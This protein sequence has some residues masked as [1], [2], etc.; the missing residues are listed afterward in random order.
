V[1]SRERR[2]REPGMTKTEVREA[3]R[4][5]GLSTADKPAAA[6]LASRFAYGVRITEEGLARVE[7]AEESLLS[8]GF[9]VVRVRD[10]GKDRA[11]VEVAAED[12]SRLLP[13]SEEV[14]DEL[15]RLGFSQV[16]ID[17]RGYRR[18]A[19]NEGMLLTVGPRAPGTGGGS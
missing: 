10:L 3:S 18:G 19:L 11:R 6:C 12:V 17:E 5:V 13:I 16:T 1:F 14:R 4:I 15:A 9:P 7:R 8:R 2:Y